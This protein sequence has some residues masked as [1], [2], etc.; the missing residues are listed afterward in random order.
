MLALPQRCSGYDSELLLQGA[1][2]HSLVGELRSQVL[3]GLDQKTSKNIEH[4]VLLLKRSTPS[5]GL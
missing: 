4:R 5:L 3:S 2:V 1:Q